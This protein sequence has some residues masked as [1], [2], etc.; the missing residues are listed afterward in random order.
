MS[1]YYTT[2]S[3]PVGNSTQVDT[4]R[5]IPPTPGRYL[6]PPPNPGNA[7]PIIKIMNYMERMNEGQW[8]P[9]SREGDC[10]YMGRREVSSPRVPPRR[11]N[12]RRVPG[13]VEPGP[14]HRGCKHRTGAE[15]S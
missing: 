9:P 14:L 11:G 3:G 15:N 13:G 10:V 12:P 8:R 2:S 6:E 4:S 1:Q 7:T 5:P